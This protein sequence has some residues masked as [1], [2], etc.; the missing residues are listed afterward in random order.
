[1]QVLVGDVIELSTNQLGIVVDVNGGHPERPVVRLFNGEEAGS[2]L[3]RELDLAKHSDVG[4]SRIVEPWH[5]C[6]HRQGE[7]AR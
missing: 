4:I 6:R 5:A 1:M 2:Q 3:A 7:W